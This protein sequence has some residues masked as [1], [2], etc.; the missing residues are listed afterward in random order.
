ME[1]SMAD[2]EKEKNSPWVAIVVAALGVVG[3][4]GAAYF[5]ATAKATDTVQQ[6]AKSQIVS[7][8]RLP[9][10]TVIQS[11]LTYEQI[12][13]VS[14]NAWAPADGRFVPDDSAYSQLTGRAQ[15]PDLR[16]RFVRR[17]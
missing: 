9:V 8:T 16:G 17:P 13:A 7:E 1:A 4:V 11:M 2:G 3:S 14:G 12:K 10:G 5:T 15:V 6:A